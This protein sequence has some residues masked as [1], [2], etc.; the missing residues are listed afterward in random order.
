MSIEQE[1]AETR[2]RLAQ[3]TKERDALVDA[4]IYQNPW[5]GEFVAAIPQGWRSEW[6][7]TREDAV[8]TLMSYVMRNRKAS[9]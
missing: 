8:T 9:T 4:L 2:T 7:S 1:L 5:D 3:V 6:T